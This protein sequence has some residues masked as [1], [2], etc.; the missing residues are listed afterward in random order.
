[1]A[2]PAAW[3]ML[4][5]NME[6]SRDQPIH[7]IISI[8]PLVKLLRI[9]SKEK[10]SA[11][12]V[13]PDGQILLATTSS[14]VAE[15]RRVGRVCILR[16][17][18]QFK[19]LDALK[20]EFVSTVSHDLR[21]PLTLIRGYTTMLKMVGEL[22][23][24][25]S[26]YLEKI[27]ESVENMDRLVN[28]LLDLSRIEAGVGL[29]LEKISVQDVIERVVSEFQSRTDQKRI[30]LTVVVDQQEIPLI[31]A[32]RALLQQAFHNL[33]ENA[34]KFTE[35]GGEVKIVLEVH[36]DQLVFEVEDTGIGISPADQQRM[37]EKFYRASRQTV[38]SERGSG[39]GLAIVKSIAERHGGRV[40]FESQ[41]GKGSTFF[42]AIPLHQTQS[43]LALD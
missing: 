37:F 24:Q 1:L 11:E 4:G 18:T 7:R 5:I 33:V 20:S 23:D 2:N 34:I 12:I 8:E 26:N 19:K 22:N 41:L 42:L 9:S 16:D 10:Q 3:Q 32:D 17:V 27:A 13:L 15:G 40:W 43:E 25:Q 30:K 21:S 31:E 29:Q 38:R 39:L 14:V 6:A 35:P 36:N 28:N